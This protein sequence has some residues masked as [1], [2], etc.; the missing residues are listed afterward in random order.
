MSERA[1]RTR[2]RKMD[3]ISEIS[4]LLKTK[5]LVFGTGNTV[6]KLKVGKIAKVFLTS[7]CPKAVS[8]DIRH[9]SG[10]SSA[11]VVQLEVPNDELAQI[12]KKPFS[13]SV[14]SVI[15]E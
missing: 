14:L 13:I 9:Y 3:A 12:C 6:K 8:E 10:L 7:N 5:K 2:I 1:M 15:K 4:K 11:E